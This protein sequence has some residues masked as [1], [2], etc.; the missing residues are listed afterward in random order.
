MS[1][2]T[3][4]TNVNPPPV[5]TG[6]GT[7]VSY[8]YVTLIKIVP[9]FAEYLKNGCPKYL[10]LNENENDTNIT[11][12]EA[13]T[14]TELTALTTLVN[15]YV[16]PSVYYQL[17][18][19][20]NFPMMSNYTSSTSLLPVGSIIY[21][22]TN[23]A[24][25][26]MNQVKL[27]IAMQCLNTATFT[28]TSTGN[29]TFEL[30]DKTRNVVIVPETVIDVSSILTNW[31]LDTEANTNGYPNGYLTKVIQ[32]YDFANAFPNHDIILQFNLSSCETD[33]S[34]AVECIQF[35]W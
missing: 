23:S 29:V 6:V 31:S 17:T 25:L 28:N 35:L 3:P 14:E 24:T 7:Q 2:I 33:V 12:S 22:N 1:E 8:D 32:L 18:K 9:A 13:L 27:V 19:V 15:N 16:D 5:E 10:A 11:V 4:T 20:D 34:V 21:S 26:V 30:L